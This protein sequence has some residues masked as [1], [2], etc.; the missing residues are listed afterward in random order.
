MARTLK[1]SLLWLITSVRC[2]VMAPNELIT[3]GTRRR[4]VIHVDHALDVS[5][6]KLYKASGLGSK[7]I[8][9]K[10]TLFSQQLRV[11][12]LDLLDQLA[13][14]LLCHTSL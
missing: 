11:K 13:L 6:I 10:H 1:F 7:S 12:I 9:F 3:G 5:E 4:E 14:Y 2:V 8:L